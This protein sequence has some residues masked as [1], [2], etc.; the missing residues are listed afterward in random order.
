MAWSITRLVTA[1]SLLVLAGAVVGVGYRMARADLEAE[2]YRDRL[3]SLA[4]EYEQLRGRYNDAVRRTAVTELLVRDGE[5]CVRIRTAEGVVE[6][7]PTPFD[8]AGEI[9][10]DYALLDGRLWLRRIFDAGTR[11][12][13]AFVVDP[14]LAGI[15]WQRAGALHGKAVYRSLA[16]GRWIVSVSGDGSLGLTHAGPEEPDA[17]LVH[18]PPVREYAELEAEIQAEVGTVGLFDLARRLLDGDR[19]EAP[20]SPG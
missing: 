15:D 11:P 13:D 19:T 8:P 4:G 16:E 10:V 2:I 6:T 14:G 18:A 7:L 9:F 3:E 5:L 20:A 12:S 17:E 1:A